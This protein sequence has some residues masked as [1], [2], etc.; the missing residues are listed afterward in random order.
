M[1]RVDWNESTEEK[2]DS[3]THSE[4][5]TPYQMAKWMQYN[6]EA[7]KTAT[8]CVG[9]TT[10]STGIMS[11]NWRHYRRQLLVVISNRNHTAN[12]LQMKLIYMF[13]R[14]VVVVVAVSSTPNCSIFCECTRTK[15]NQQLSIRCETKLNEYKWT[16]RSV[17][18]LHFAVSRFISCA[19][20]KLGQN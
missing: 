1:E 11:P 2:R 8:S 10:F 15:S 3:P 4:K 17:S 19:H 14:L 16:Q 13:R 6:S 9:D 12:Q 7:C 20:R 18:H 5:R